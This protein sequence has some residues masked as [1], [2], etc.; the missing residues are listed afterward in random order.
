LLTEDSSRP[1][2]DGGSGDWPESPISSVEN[3]EA[4]LK[5]HEEQAKIHS[6]RAR[7][8]KRRLSLMVLLTM[9]MAAEI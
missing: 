2:T 3:I 4:S 8:L 5:F 1:Q 9:P 7:A 6:E